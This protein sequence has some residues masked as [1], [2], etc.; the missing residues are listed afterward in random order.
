M[1]FPF[2]LSNWHSRK[3]CLAISVTAQYA[4]RLKISQWLRVM[5]P[6]GTVKA[7]HTRSTAPLQPQLTATKQHHNHTKVLVTQPLH[8]H[9]S[10]R[11][12]IHVPQCF[13]SLLLP[14]LEFSSLPVQPPASSF[15]P[16]RFHSGITS[17]VVLS[18]P[19]KTD[20]TMFSWV[21]FVSSIYF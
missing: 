3:M 15:H 1:L 19:P 10:K 21:S 18:G 11:T 7:Q 16:P 8:A 12:H 9:S 13:K 17:P 2:K 14:F 4:A 5:S 6:Q 20:L